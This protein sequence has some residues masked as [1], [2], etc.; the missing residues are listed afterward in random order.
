MNAYVYKYI[1][2]DVLTIKSFRVFYRSHRPY[3]LYSDNMLYINR[4]YCM[5]E[6]DMHD[7]KRVVS[8][9]QNT[10]KQTLMHIPFIFTVPSDN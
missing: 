4:V 8:I 5:H 9:V 7:E 2:I 1:F 3:I 10:L 6:I